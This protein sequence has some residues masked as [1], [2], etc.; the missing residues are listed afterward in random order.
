MTTAIVTSVLKSKVERA[1]SF[2]D[3]F[4]AKLNGLR[5]EGRYR[6]FVEL[7]RPADRF[8]YAVWHAPDGPRDVVM[9]CSNDYLNMAHDA[10]VA[11]T[12]IDAVKQGATGAGGTR[13]IGGTHHEHVE[14]ERVLAQ[15][16]G[17]EAALTFTSGWVANLTALSVL[18]S[19][20]PNAV[21]LSDA[22]NHNSMI[23][24][25]RRGTAPCVVFRHNDVADLATKLAALPTAQPKIIALESLYSMDGSVAPLA[26]IC[27]V[28]ERFGAF[29]YLDEVHAVGLYGVRGAGQAELQ[30]V[31]HRIDLIQGTLGKAV[32]LQ[33]GYIAGRQAVV[34]GVRSLGGGFI[35]STA[36]PPMIAAGARVSIEKLIRAKA[37]RN[38]QQ[39]HVRLLQQGLRRLRLPMLESPSHIVPV[40]VGDAARC[41]QASD[42]LLQRFGIYVQPINYPTVARGTERLRFTPGPKHTPEHIHHLVDALDQVWTEL[43]LPRQQGGWWC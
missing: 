35:F 2:E 34:D 6:V 37:Q 17:K 5:S 41:K 23:E 18:G 43:D 16:H 33:G 38:A 31:S 9:W 7:E 15:W 11:A 24:G 25:I 36:M 14:L 30:C 39:Q 28:A 29:T 27:D 1:P 22:D 19:I 12:M 13:N 32:G 8:P 21:V 40:V 4:A 3:A 10:A 42:L 26:A 20:L